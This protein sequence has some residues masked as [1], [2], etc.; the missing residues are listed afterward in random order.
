MDEPK[1]GDS[2]PNPNVYPDDPYGGRAAEVTAPPS[3]AMVKT[4]GGGRT[5]PPPPPPED[6][7]DEEDSGM[8]RMSFLE[9]L[10]ELR[11]RLIK[12]IVGLGVAFLLCLS[13]SMQLWD[14]IRAPAFDAM[15]KIGIK[16]PHLVIIEPMESFMII[17]F[18]L[19]L[20][21]A[22]FVGSPWVLYQVW[23]FIAPGLYKKE[24]RWAIPFVLTTAGLFIAGGLF[25]YFVAFRY[26]L[27]FLLGIGLSGGVQP[28]V[29]VTN[30]FDLFCDV[31]LGVALVF[32]MPVVIF[33]LTLLRIASPRWLMAH[34]RYAIL[35]IVILAAI[36]TPTPDVF[37]LMLFAVPMCLLYFVGV[38]AGYLLVMKREGHKFPWKKVLLWTA[39][40]LLLMAGFV[41]F[42]IAHYHYHLIRHWPF[43][44]K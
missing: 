11:S 38:F 8:L 26:G 4:G 2:S 37:N 19:P 39:L 17:W 5:P 44:K 10:E 34:S 22:L 41:Y 15:V 12:A 6:P 35:G 40:G 25:A 24:R 16:D 23:A 31:M 14:V 32:E 42:E 27:A 21:V 20:V 18:K 30:Y 9:H 7:E 3:K 33:F 29:T 28:M 36:V 43:L 1:N 13:F